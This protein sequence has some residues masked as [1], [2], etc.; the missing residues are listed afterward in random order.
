MALAENVSF[1]SFGMIC[2]LLRLSLL[3]DELPRDRRDSDGFFSTK[4]VNRPSVSSCNTTDL[5]LV[6]LK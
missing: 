5:P 1:K 4:L 6:T 2:R 3:P